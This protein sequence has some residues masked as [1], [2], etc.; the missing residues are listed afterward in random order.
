MKRSPLKRKPM[1]RRAKRS[2]YAMRGRDTPY[3]LWVKTLR[4]AAKTYAMPWR[5]DAETACSWVTEA[6]HMGDRGLGRKADDRTCVPMC[7]A[8]HRERTDHNGMFRFATKAQLREWRESLICSVQEI[9]ADRKAL[10]EPML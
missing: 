5:V 8:H 10:G 3:M 4:C 9:A 7:V 2:K 1:R 6:D